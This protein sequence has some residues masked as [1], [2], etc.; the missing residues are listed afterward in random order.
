MPFA[1]SLSPARLRY[2]CQFSSGGQF[3]G[4]AVR[5]LARI[6]ID[7][8]VATTQMTSDQFFRE[9]VLDVSLDG[10]TQRARAV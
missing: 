4:R 9:R 8:D 6:E 1:F 2:L 3:A 5:E 10:A 7:I